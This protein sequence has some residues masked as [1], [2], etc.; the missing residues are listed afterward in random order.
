MGKKSRDKGKR[1]ERELAK[2]LAKTLSID[3][4]RGVQYS[5]SPDSPD[6]VTSLDGVHWECKRS[7][8]FQLYPSLEQSATDSGDNI[9]VVAHRRNHKKWVFVCYLDDLPEIAEIINENR[10]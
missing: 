3:A 10:H 6:V 8:R 7:E 4:K 2:E 9:P 1:G 5:G